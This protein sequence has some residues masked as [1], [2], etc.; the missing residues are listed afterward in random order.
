MNVSRRQFVKSA[1]AATALG[2]NA[3][4]A[5]RGVSII[6][7]PDQSAPVQWALAELA[8]SITA[9]GATVF[10]CGS[11]SQAKPDDL[12]LVVS[13]GTGTAESFELS[14]TVIDKRRVLQV[15]GGDVRGLVYALL[16]LSDRVKYSPDPFAVHVVETPSNA[17]RGIN[18]LFTSDVEDKPWFNDREMWPQYLTMLAGHR[19]N[20]FSLALGIGYD[21]IRQVTDAYFLFPYPFF[22][23]VPGYAVR[24]SPLPDAERDGNL[25]ML[26]F[27]SEQTVA[28][29][30]EFQLGLWMHGYEWIDS[31][32]P[33]YTI[34]GVTK[35]NHAAY[36]RDALRL[37]LQKCPAISGVTFRVHGESGVEEGSYDFWKAVFEGLTSCGR[38]V[39]LDMHSKGM[40][41]SMLDVAVAT[42]RQVTL[43]PKFWAEHMGMPYHQTDIRDQEQP[44]PGQ[45]GNALMKF[46][47]GSRSFL[48]YGYGD[49]LREDRP[50]KVVHRI[51]PGTQRLLLWG[52]PLTAAQYSKAFSFC[53]SAGVEICEPLSF[54]GR[55]GT[56]IAGDRCAYADATLRPR[57]DWQKYEYTY[58]VWGRFLFN[59]NAPPESTRRGLDQQF[60]AGAEHLAAALSNASRILPIVTTTHGPSAAN[61]SY[62][63]EMYLNQS[64]FDAEHFAPYSDT[65]A[66]KVFGNASPFDPQ[67]FLRINEFAD[68]LL[69]GQIDGKYSPVEVAQ[70]LEDF[71]RATQEQLAAADTKAVNKQTPEYRRL[72]VDAGIQAG[73][74]QFFAAKFRAAVLY[75][76]F[77]KTGDEQALD[78]CLNQYR[79]ARARWS[80]LSNLAKD[81]YQRDITVGEH[82]QLRGHWLDRLPA[83]DRDIA[84][85]E[86][87][88]QREAAAPQARVTAAIKKVVG[89]PA[90]PPLIASH[91]PPAKLQ[92]GNDLEIGISVK[93][94][95]V[96][97]HYRHVDQAERY[98]TAEM[99]K[100]GDRY[101][102]AIPAAYTNS[103]YPIAY[104]FEIKN[105]ENSWLFPGFSAQ[106]TGT[107][108]F[109]VRQ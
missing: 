49:L 72:V 109:V 94:T 34:E 2:A 24:A 15:R 5:T 46:S 100:G 64:L 44:K 77:E 73:L 10:R 50:W 105:V 95:A 55:R 102:A 101:L 93:A 83:I 6:S 13:A 53:G 67:L 37:L 38:E 22:L 51:W 96:L 59:H 75:R 61:N 40:D 92:P 99:K 56:G 14:P 80:E 78:E 85:L 18:R 107:P 57:W 32:H 71:S 25:A 36:C 28:R 8:R 4:A 90:R 9:H 12:C 79:K 29:G 3:V 60:G 30:M 86:G 68:N 20:R 52:D 43:S 54:K 7:T 47:A 39:R 27:I 21:F 106:L 35:Q 98:Q 108:Y 84:G 70:W 42:K 89:R 16:E 11:V 88:L 82:P 91:T 1:G 65:M 103:Q 81:V 62:W 63:P 76:L 58:R 33:S 87:R 66:P 48:R 74:G 26:Q 69:S 19:F 104:Y 23:Q 97:L 31:P 17:V 41:Q 45:T